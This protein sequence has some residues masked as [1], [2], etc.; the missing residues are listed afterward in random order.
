[1]KCRKL[2]KKIRH[3]YDKNLRVFSKCQI[4]SCSRRFRCNYLP[5]LFTSCQFNS[6]TIC[7]LFSLFNDVTRLQSHINHVS[8]H[9]LSLSIKLLMI[10]RKTSWDISS[11]SSNISNWSLID[12]LLFYRFSNIFFILRCNRRTK[13]CF[14]SLFFADFVSRG[15]L[16]T[17]YGK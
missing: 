2:N 15:Q 10:R 13:N 1:M 6:M 14:S 7:C 3:F 12:L 8:S 4:L 5:N 11:D 16:W 9:G 17:L